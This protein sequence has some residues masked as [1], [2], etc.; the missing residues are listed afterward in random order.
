MHMYFVSLWSS[1]HEVPFAD[2]Y[3]LLTILNIA[4]TCKTTVL[5]HSASNGIVPIP[6][7]IVDQ[8]GKLK[9]HEWSDFAPDVFVEALCQLKQITGRGS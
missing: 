8:S 9:V 3:A 6:A 7:H 5:L 1:H 4:Y 2:S